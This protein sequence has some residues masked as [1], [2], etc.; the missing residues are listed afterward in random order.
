MVSAPLSRREAEPCVEAIDVEALL[1]SA[2]QASD[3]LK[4]MAHPTRMFI[5]CAL[6]KGE[7]SV[8]DLEGMLHMRQPAVSQ[9]LARLRADELVATRREGKKIYYQLARPEVIGVIAAL[10]EAFCAR[11][12]NLDRSS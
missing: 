6:I 1:A 12:E 9:Q 3:L 4:A 2:G 7:R 8:T 5:L 11:T 10:H